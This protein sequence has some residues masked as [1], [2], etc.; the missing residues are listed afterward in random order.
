MN[1]NM[2]DN[3]KKIILPVLSLI[4][5]CTEE[6]GVFEELERKF[7]LFRFKAIPCNW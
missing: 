5:I 7:E 4:H 1:E 3:H 2:K 6:V